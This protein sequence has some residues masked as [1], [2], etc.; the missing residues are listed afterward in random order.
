MYQRSQRTL[1]VWTLKI[2][3]VA[4]FALALASGAQ[5]AT[6]L[7]IKLPREAPAGASAPAVMMIRDLPIPPSGAV[8]TV[9]ATLCD[10]RN[11]AP[12]AT[13]FVLG[14]GDGRTVDRDVRAAMAASPELITA[15]QT[16]QKA[17]LTITECAIG[18][19]ACTTSAPFPVRFYR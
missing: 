12:L 5:G 4:G 9:N 16:D 7:S 19:R 2:G 10:S 14:E 6:S 18:G 13:L 3:C 17:S 11:P 1:N 8:V 15:L